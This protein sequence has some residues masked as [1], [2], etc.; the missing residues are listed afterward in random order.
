MLSAR[1]VVFSSVFAF[2]AHGFASD[3][4]SRVRPITTVHAQNEAKRPPSD[5]ST[6]KTENTK[7]TVPTRQTIEKGE[8]K[9]TTL[10]V[11]NSW[12]S[13]PREIMKEGVVLRDA[14]SVRVEDIVEPSLDY[15]YAT[16][17][18][19]DPFVP[20]LVA[21]KSE[22]KRD[23]ETPLVSPLQ[24]Y[25][26]QDLKVSGVWISNDRVW[27]ALIM[28]PK[29]EGIIAKVND[30]IANLEGKII[31]INDEGIKVREYRTNSDGTR[32]IF[33]SK[34]SM[35]PAGDYSMS[36]PMSSIESLPHSSSNLSPNNSPNP[37]PAPAQEKTQNPAASSV[38]KESAP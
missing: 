3:S 2:G 15:H 18:Y 25:A 32:E 34:V 9:V 20:A 1:A 38:Q 12:E 22:S 10:K 7:K 29:G 17:G 8:D 21:E 30:P 19:A 36:A 6:L 37:E 27:K 5:Q 31:A 26:L 28:T 13:A 11:E 33:D 23:A 14:F 35:S 4:K 16:F 24:R